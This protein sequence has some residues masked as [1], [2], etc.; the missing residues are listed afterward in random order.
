MVVSRQ[1]DVISGS[2]H[3]P[4]EH[5]PANA[6]GHFVICL[7][8]AILR[9]LTHI[10]RMCAVSGVDFSELT[11]RY[12]FLSQYL[13]EVTRELPEDLHWTA[14]NPWWTTQLKRWE[15]CYP[16]TRLPLRDMLIEGEIEESGRLAFLL[17][18]LVEEDSRFG[19]LLAELQQPLAFRRP[20]L[21]FVGQVL[22]E[23]GNPT[24]T[25]AWKLCRSLYSFGYLT[26]ENENA[27]RAEW[28]LRVPSLLWDAAR[29][30][31]TRLASCWCT[32]SEAHAFPPIDELIYP[33]EFIARLSRLPGVIVRPESQMTAGKARLLILRSVH[34]NDLHELVGAIA[35]MTRRNFVAVNGQNPEIGRAHV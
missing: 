4:F 32:I 24:G 35:R 7:Y 12:P 28:V 11:N 23:T 27:P 9:L 6:E 21:E 2:T 17:I 14:A 30:E 10:H 13:E 3:I 31:T 1:T 5:V 8:A 16:G 33:P 19:T 20:T 22:G 25:D 26:T 29:G 34:G 15:H 18:G